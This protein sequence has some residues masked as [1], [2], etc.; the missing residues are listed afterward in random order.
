MQPIDEFQ[1]IVE[2]SQEISNSENKETSFQSS[3]KD[4]NFHKN[5]YKDVLPLEKTRVKLNPIV[6]QN[7]F[8]LYKCKLCRFR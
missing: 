5:R 7:W 4:Y 6:G 1:R 2:W 8:G 3:L